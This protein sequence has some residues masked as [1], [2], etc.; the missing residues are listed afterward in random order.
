MKVKD[1]IDQLQCYDPT[2]DVVVSGGGDY[3]NVVKVVV[4]A[5]YSGPLV[6]VLELYGL[7]GAI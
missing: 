7:G 2:L 4:G 1:L 5:H 3:A 6:N